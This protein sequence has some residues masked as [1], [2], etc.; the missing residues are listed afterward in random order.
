M[1]NVNG[2]PRNDFLVGSPGDDVIRGFAG[3]DFLDG[4]TG[5]DTLDGG[6]GIDRT[7]LRFANSA[8]GVAVNLSLPQS[9]VSTDLGTKT[10]ISIESAIIVGSS[11]NDNITG[12]VGNDVIS[13]GAGDDR[14]AGGFGDDI[15]DGG[16][17]VDMAFLTFRN[18]DT[19]VRLSLASSM[20][21]AETDR[22]TLTLISIERGNID[23]S[24]HDDVITGGSGN[25]W[26]VGYLGDD[27]INGGRGDDLL[28]GDGF[29]YDGGGN[30]WINGGPGDDTLES[31]IGDDI[32]IG[33][34][35]I[36]R[37]TLD[38]GANPSAV[39]F[40]FDGRHT[41]VET[42]LGTKTLIGI[43]EVDILGSPNDD[44][45]VGGAYDDF[46]GGYGGNDTITGGSGND[47]LSGDLDSVEA[48]TFV[49]GLDSGDDV[50][51]D[52]QLGTDTL[53]LVGGQTIS[54]LQPQET[55]TLV[56]FG[57][58]SSVLLAGTLVSNPDDLLML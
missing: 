51:S 12:G 52:F 15:L 13:G 58:G 35:G 38:F 49:F 29:S 34:S 25:D 5:N 37:T 1:A 18:S 19:P 10:L 21:V 36:D 27:R 7:I 4:L 24:D 2:T 40:T 47:L 14:L 20:A 32:L 44:V 16:A 54:T 46:I 53:E 22:G 43:E 9:V 45:L 26:V 50:I 17:G 42:A 39:T 41:V 8:V 30:D 31:G 3:D 23:G 28:F 11:H 6:E 48:D 33:G 57:D 56:L 55:D